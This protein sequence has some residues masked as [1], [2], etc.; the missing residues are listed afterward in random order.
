MTQTLNYL[1]YG[2]DWVDIKHNL[3]PSL[4]QY[5]FTGKERDEETGYGYFGARYMDHELMTGWLSVDPM[6]DKYPGISPYAYCAWNPVRLVDPDGRDFETI[7]DHDKKTITI[8]AQFYINGGTEKQ[9]RAFQQAIAEWNSCEFNVN[10]PGAEKGSDNVYRVCFDINN[11]NGEG[12]LNHVSFLSDKDFNASFPELKDA[13]GVSDGSN[14]IMRNSSTNNQQLA[15]EM[16]HCLGMG[17]QYMIKEGLMFKAITNKGN[18]QVAR[19]GSL[20]CRS[21]LS[22]CGF[23]FKGPAQPPREQ[24]INTIT[25]GSVPIGFNDAELSLKSLTGYEKGTKKF[26]R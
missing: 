23:K 19:L 25:I 16:G 26:R 13:G 20:E 2:E 17:D 10:F 15:H 22:T 11:S 21:L 8:R 6:A 14:I 12:P 9:R 24:C 5:T 3:D 18:V 7:V 1:P 4:G